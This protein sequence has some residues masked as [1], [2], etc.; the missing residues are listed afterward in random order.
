M[1][2]YVVAYL[3]F[4]NNLV[5][6]ATVF[7]LVRRIS[8]LPSPSSFAGSL[9]SFEKSMFSSSFAELGENAE[10]DPTIE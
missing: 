4:L 2:I 9:S 8:I 6:L 3:R 1:I 7:T 5:S 10:L